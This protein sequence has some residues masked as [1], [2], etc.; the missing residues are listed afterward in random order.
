MTESVSVN[1]VALHFA[2]RG[3]RDRPALVFANSLGTDLRIWD[4]VIARLGP[5]FRTL[6]YDKRGHG[7]SDIG[8]TPYA[9]ETHVADLIGLLDARGVTGAIICGLSVGGQIALG[10]AAR[11]PDLVRAL[12]LSDTAHRIGPP[13]T[14]DAR[15]G[16][17][18]LGGIVSIADAVMERWFTEAYRQAQPVALAIWRNMLVRTPATGYSGTCAALRDADLTAAARGIRVPTLCLCG[19]QDA[20][21]PPDLVQSLAALV[22][23][24]RFSAVADAG[25]LP[26]IEQPQRVADLILES[27][28]E[29]AFA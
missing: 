25:H 21:T 22:P 16:A 9:I 13:E 19:D 29:S 11:R 15:I 5:G 24:A 14:W 20:A 6:C 18:E 7:L 12:V 23:G 8:R 4:G 2:D 1:G 27:A 10:L 28:Q 26:G 17:V 3:P